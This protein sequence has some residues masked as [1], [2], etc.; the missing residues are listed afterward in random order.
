MHPDILLFDEPTSAL[1][2]T[3]VS[4]VLSVMKGLAEQGLTMLVVTHEMRFAREASSRVFYMD[5]GEC[6]E[7]GPPEQI[8]EHPQRKE[9]HDF[10]F[11]VR[12]WQ[13]DIDSLDYDFPGMVASL[14][15]FCA[16]QFFGRRLTNACQVVV[17]ELVGQLLVPAARAHDLS[18][19]A[20]GI[21]LSAAEGGEGCTLDLRYDKVMSACG[22]DP[23]DVQEDDLSARIVAGYSKRQPTDQPGH[24]SYLIG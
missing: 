11:R 13:W 16:R 21:T 22:T 19:P 17:E 15:S 20:I 1:D 14:E 6:W 12:S 18:D 7:A 3:M 8:F 24:A 5:R 4:E 10:I 23:L 9:T 2:P